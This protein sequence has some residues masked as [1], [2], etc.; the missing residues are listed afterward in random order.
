MHTPDV[1]WVR[2]SFVGLVVVFAAYLFVCN[3]NFGALDSK[4]EPFSIQTSST[5]TGDIRAMDDMDVTVVANVVDV[6]SVSLNRMPTATELRRYH[7]AVADGS[8]TY[9][10]LKTVLEGSAEYARMIRMQTNAVQ[11]E[12]VPRFTE[13]QLELS[14]A[15]LYKDVFGHAFDDAE[16]E[17]LLRKYRYFRMDD[18]RM[19]RFLLVLRE[20]LQDEST[21][22]QQQ[23][24]AASAPQQAQQAQASAEVTETFASPTTLPTH[25]DLNYTTL[26]SLTERPNAYCRGG[27][28]RRDWWELPFFSNETDNAAG[29][30]NRRNKE[31]LGFACERASLPDDAAT[32][33][34]LQ[35]DPDWVM[36]MKTSDEQ[37]PLADH[38]SAARD[39]TS[40]SGT[41]L[42]D[43][44]NTS[45]D[46]P[47]LPGAPATA[48]S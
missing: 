8:L 6:F 18:V 4:L 12:M 13:R 28:Q 15:K 27:K 23:A 46:Q 48:A 9:D 29:F 10:R 30:I 11:S 41:L 31:E 33:S 3:R 19:R 14:V 37:A 21:P 32:W 20:F 35:P 42:T 36:P 5:A 47:T 2:V 1:G 38:V 22:Q 16:R 34:L 43:E 26:E 44:A 45:D 7:D 24:Q 25:H 17:Y 39:W 40:L